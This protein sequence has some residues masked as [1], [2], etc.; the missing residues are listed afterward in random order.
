MSESL[1]EIIR[2]RIAARGPMP[3]RR[4][5]ELALYHLSLG[6]YASGRA[7]V[8]RKGD[9][10]TNVSVGPLFGRLLARQIVE[11]WERLGSPRAFS[12]IEQGA[13]EGALAADVLGGLREFSPDCFAATIY[14]IVEPF[15]VLADRQRNRLAKFAGRVEWKN[16]LREVEIECGVHLSNELPDAFPV[17]LVTRTSG[18]WRER[19][20]IERGG[21][22]AFDDGPLTMPALRDAC[23]QIP[24][25]LPD[26]YCTEVNLAA[27]E[28]IADVA[29][30]IRRGFFLAV[31]YGFTRDEYYAPWRM[32]GTLSAYAD[33]R[34]ESDPLA[35][36]GEIDLT[37]HVE[38]TSL[39]EAATAAGLS[40][41]GF[42]DQHHFMVGLGA[43]HFAHEANAAERRAFQTLMH[44]QFMGTAFKVVCFAK[45]VEP[46]LPLA[47]FRFARPSVACGELR[48]IGK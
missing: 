19:M 43:A 3:F 16:S 22:F 44:P 11:M 25:L 45:A 39:I 6:Y 24:G 10:F 46:S 41:A 42:T 26:G 14:R 21:R 23:A 8:G 1:S 47:G 31:D 33:H 9:F 17:H 18:E 36:P 30:S 29:R 32:S 38:F 37:A 2:S 12:L 48:A 28:W 35:R 5:M 13:H 27:R 34:R 7:R 4:F 40:L 15:A 20:V